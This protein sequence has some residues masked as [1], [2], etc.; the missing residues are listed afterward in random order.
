MGGGLPYILA[1]IKK[2]SVKILARKLKVVNGGPLICR[3]FLCWGK[4]II[5]YAVAVIFL[6][7][8]LY[9]CYVKTEILSYVMSKGKILLVFI[10]SFRSFTGINLTSFFSEFCVE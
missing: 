2:Y 7:S 6:N 1:Q 10:Y 8:V 5:V 9:F 3:V 4:T